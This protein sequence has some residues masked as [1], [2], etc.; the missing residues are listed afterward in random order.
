[1][2]RSLI[3]AAAFSTALGP[4]SVRAD[5]VA[6]A[7]VF[8]QYCAPCHS[9][10]PGTQRYG[11]SLDNL[12]G[13]QAG[14]HPGFEYSTGLPRSGLIWN[15]HTLDDWLRNPHAA[16][17]AARMPFEGLENPTQRHDVIEF[18]EHEAAPR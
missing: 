8:K 6:G 5:V 13:R 12:M 4:C 10:K 17:S 18:L 16:V 14:M 3:L 1:M 9:M 11:P 2:P 15:G 7:R